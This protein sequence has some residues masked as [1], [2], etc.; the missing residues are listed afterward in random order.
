MLIIWKQFSSVATDSKLNCR[1]GMPLTWPSNTSQSGLKIYIGFFAL[2][3]HP[4]CPQPCPQHDA[5]TIILHSGEWWLG[6]P[7]NLTFIKAKLISFSIICKVSTMSSSF[8][9]TAL[10]DKVSRFVK[11]L[12]C[13]QYNLSTASTLPLDCILK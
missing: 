9:L 10:L 6:F 11:C 5:T 7:L 2:M 8:F 12:W 4:Y 3:C 1:A 13:G